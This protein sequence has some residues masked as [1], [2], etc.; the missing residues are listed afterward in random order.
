MSVLATATIATYALVALGLAA[1]LRIG[2]RLPPESPVFT[3]TFSSRGWIAA[4]AVAVLA[5]VFW[6]ISAV[7]VFLLV[8]RA[9]R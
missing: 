9:M 2:W 7:A 1:F 5:V 3:Y 8:R 4:H 6:P